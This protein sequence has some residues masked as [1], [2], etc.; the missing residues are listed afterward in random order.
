MSTATLTDD[1]ATARR[2]KEAPLGDSRSLSFGTTSSS[3]GRQSARY[4]FCPIARV[5]PRQRHRR[6]QRATRP[7]TWARG[8]P[9]LSPSRGYSCRTRWLHAFEVAPQ[10][11]HRE[12]V[13]AR[14][15]RRA[16]VRGSARRD[17]SRRTHADSWI[18]TPGG[19]ARS[20]SLLD[21]VPHQPAVCGIG[22]Q[23]AKD[24]PD[25]H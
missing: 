5:R 23:E 21:P 10:H 8:E 7:P 22:G 19:S 14:R 20:H 25:P 18:L 24:H 1:G 6:S 3:A 17:L 15:E 2:K 9:L 16:C 4:C 11:G 13:A 12:Q